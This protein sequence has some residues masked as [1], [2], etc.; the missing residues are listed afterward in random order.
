MVGLRAGGYAVGMLL[1]LV[2]APLLV[3][4]L[5]VADFG[6]YI[7]IN[8]LVT[9]VAGLSDLGLNSLGVREWAREQAGERRA[10][11]RDLLGARLVFS[12]AGVASAMVFALIAGY[13]SARL[14]GTG[15]ACVGLIVMAVQSALTI[16]LAG[17][18]RQG[19]IAAAERGGA[20][21]SS[22]G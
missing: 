22:S 18:L 5:G 17:R 8:S 14:L 11:M 15:L 3:R 6:I 7:T 9:I 10:L 4:H 13:D 1:G 16:P 2:A 12:F 19:W 20:R 21:P